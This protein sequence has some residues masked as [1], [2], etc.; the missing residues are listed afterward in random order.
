LT[1]VLCGDI[2]NELPL[3]TTNS[4]TAFERAKKYRLSLKESIGK[5][6]QLLLLKSRNNGEN[7]KYFDY[8][9]QLKDKCC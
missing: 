7:R 6:Q 8:L 3:G 2:V 5:E 4:F 9:N 1:V